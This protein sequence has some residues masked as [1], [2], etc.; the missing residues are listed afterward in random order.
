MKGREL[1][2]TCAIA[3]LAMNCIVLSQSLSNAQKS[4]ALNNEG[5]EYYKAGSL[6]QALAA[7]LRSLELEPSAETLNNIGVTLGDLGRYAEAIEYFKKGLATFPGSAKLNSNLGTALYRTGDHAAA[8]VHLREAI[9]LRPD[10]VRPYSDLGLVLTELNRP[11]EAI[12]VLQ[13]AVRLADHD[14]VVLHNLGYAYFTARKYK[15]GLAVLKRSVELDPNVAH[16]RFLL[17]LSHAVTG[18]RGEALKH[19]AYLKVRAPDLAAR[20]FTLL[21][22]NRVIAAPQNIRRF[23]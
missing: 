6:Q 17:S 4:A 20:L 19:Y 1:F 11:N 12:K 9:R 22:Q 18:D 3:I 16:A 15:H 23:A 10:L 14:A 7:Y 13:N 21:N 5:T 2:V 8:I